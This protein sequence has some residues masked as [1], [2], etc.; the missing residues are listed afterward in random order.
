MKHHPQLPYTFIHPIAKIL[1][2][3][4]AI[5]PTKVTVDNTGTIDEEHCQVN[6][7]LHQIK[8]HI[9]AES[10]NLDKWS[11]FVQTD[12][13]IYHFYPDINNILKN[14]SVSTAQYNHIK[15]TILTGFFKAIA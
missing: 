15:T 10:D 4:V 14:S 8:L 3:N 11:E 9:P 13:S 12:N 7:T 6:N 5:A 1:Q 2:P